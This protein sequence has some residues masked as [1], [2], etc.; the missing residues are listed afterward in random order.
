MSALSDR[1]Y[2]MKK[3]WDL[4]QSQAFVF[5][6]TK[7]LI[8]SKVLGAAE[9]QLTLFSRVKDCF[10]SSNTNCFVSFRQLPIVS[11]RFVSSIT[12]CFVSFRFVEYHKPFNV[13]PTVRSAIPC[14]E[15]TLLLGPTNAIW[16]VRVFDK[17]LSPNRH[18]YIKKTT[19]FSIT[20]Q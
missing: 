2:F 7:L 9:E 12:N 20:L 1:A 19:C 15:T 8:V 3:I 6:E 14:G 10:V 17:V 4:R 13:G 5:S 18:L 16:T 11:F